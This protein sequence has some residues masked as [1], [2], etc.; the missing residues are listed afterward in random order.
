MKEWILFNMCKVVNV[1][2]ELLQTCISTGNI[3]ICTHIKIL[4]LK[5]KFNILRIFLHRRKLSERERFNYIKICGEYRSAAECS[6]I[7]LKSC[8]N[9]KSDDF[10]TQYNQGGYAPLEPPPINFHN[11]S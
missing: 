5:A 2:V 6:N 8:L 9:T 3:T 11:N 4:S 7:F 10:N 1:F